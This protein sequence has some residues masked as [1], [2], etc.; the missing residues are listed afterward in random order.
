MLRRSLLRC[1]IPFIGNSNAHAQTID[2][3]KWQRAERNPGIP[4]KDR[5]DTHYILLH[6]ESKHV[7]I[8]RR[9]F[10]NNFS[11]NQWLI[12]TKTPPEKQQKNECILI[13]M[14]DDWPDDWVTFMDNAA[15]ELKFIFFT[16]LHID[17]VIGLHPFCY[18]RDKNRQDTRFAYNPVDGV[19]MEKWTQ[20]CQR[21]R[22]YD[23]AEV[24]MPIPRACPNI[25]AG[26]RGEGDYL[27]GC[28]SR[29]MDAFF[30]LGDIP[31]QYIHTPGHSTGHMMLSLPTERLLFTGDVLFRDSIARVD[32]PYAC[33]DQLAHSL[34]MLE[35]FPDDTAVLPGHGAPT[36]MGYERRNNEALRRV[37]EL[38]ETG[39]RVPRVGLNDTGYF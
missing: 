2:H 29:R 16:H 20:V 23:M 39:W 6:H 32:L 15:Y 12:A 4:R 14:S 19:W 36:S 18:L 26:R 3:F 8:F 24:Q 10:A 21:Y 31:C 7:R 37:Y 28:A 9:A 38:I 13:D 35:D 1:G 25:S 33:G 22:R 5:L 27:I 11:S 34:R 30:L 17:N